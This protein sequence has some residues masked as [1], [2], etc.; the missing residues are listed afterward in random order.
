[1]QGLKFT[2]T[3]YDIKN[4]DSMDLMTYCFGSM[5]ISKF[6]FERILSYLDDQAAMQSEP[7]RLDSEQDYLLVS[8]YVDS[9]TGDAELSTLFVLPSNLAYRP[10][11]GDYEIVLRDSS[12]R[13]LARYPF[14]P[15]ESV[16]ASLGEPAPDG[17]LMIQVAVPYDQN[18][19]EVDLEGPDGRLAWVVAGMSAPQVTLR[20]PNGGEFLDGDPIMID[21]TARDTD[22]DR[23]TF[24]VDYS[25]DNGRNW[26]LLASGI[27][28]SSVEVPASSVPASDRGRMRVWVSDGIHTASDSSDT[29]FTVPNRPPVVEIS[30]PAEGVFAVV[31]QS[32]FFEALAYDPDVAS[33]ADINLQWNSS[34]DGA[35]GQRE[36]LT[37]ASLSQGTHQIMVIAD[38][39]AGGVSADTVTV[40][41]VGS[42]ED[43]PQF[44]DQLLVTPLNVHLDTSVGMSNASIFL[45]NS[46]NPDPIDWS[47]SASEPWL[48][49]SSAS[50][51]TPATLEVSVDPQALAPGEYSAVVTITNSQEPAQYVEVLVSVVIQPN[52]ACLPFIAKQ[53]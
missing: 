44:P 3:G 41:I 9:E 43:L 29:W 23:L 47:A 25:V 17:P 18:T 45:H 20:S 16:F 52:R 38:D 8:G 35:V 39:G 36:E 19:A 31:G 34:L 28:G 51:Q 48:I 21:W 14:S 46:Q 7:E 5:W 4:V 32:V 33:M 30:Q 49:L 37:L 12:R 2:E 53:P 27:T 26:Q 13:E 11:V 10:E 40:T 24:N 6:T 22:G 15:P 42:A 50:S 1:M